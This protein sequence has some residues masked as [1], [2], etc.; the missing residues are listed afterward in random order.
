MNG[1]GLESPNR[2]NLAEDLDPQEREGAIVDEGTAGGEGQHRRLLEPQC[3]Q[4]PT[5]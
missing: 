1:W 2:G 3:V 4:L 5:G